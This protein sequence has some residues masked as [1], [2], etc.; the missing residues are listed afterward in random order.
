MDA[1]GESAEFQQAITAIHDLLPVFPYCR[2]MAKTLW[3]WENDESEEGFLEGTK[4]LKQ[5]LGRHSRLDKYV[6][7]TVAAAIAADLRAEGTQPLG[8]DLEADIE[9]ALQQ[10][11]DMTEEAGV[12]WRSDGSSDTDA[13]RRQQLRQHARAWSYLWNLPNDECLTVQHVK[14]CH[15]ILMLGAIADDGK[16]DFAGRFREH[17]AYSASNGPEPTVYAPPE[18]IAERLENTIARLNPSSLES[19]ARFFERFLF[20]HPFKDGNGRLA[21]LLV[22]RSLKVYGLPIPTSLASLSPRAQKNLIKLIERYREGRDDKHSLLRLYLVEV[23]YKSWRKFASYVD[24]DALDSAD[25]L[26]PAAKRS[27]HA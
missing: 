15:R 22:S 27:K 8:G 5:H 17:N 1:K 23:I 10:C 25:A 11:D 13:A 19:I 9:A 3:W 14:H 6:Q 18:T 16:A 2:G 7:L 24:F 4:F 21:R 26:L 20:V 12:L